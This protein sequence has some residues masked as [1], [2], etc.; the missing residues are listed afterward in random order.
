M[1]NG[2]SVLYQGSSNCHIGTVCRNRDVSGLRPLLLRSVSIRSRTRLPPLY[3]TTDISI[4]T[5]SS[6]HSA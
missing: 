2:L 3:L 6:I 5:D 1:L 4:P